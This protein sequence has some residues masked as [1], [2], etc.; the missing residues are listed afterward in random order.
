L[1]RGRRDPAEVRKG[2]ALDFWRV[3][4]VEPGHRLKLVAEMK[5]PGE[6]VLELVLNEF[7]DG[8]LEIRQY[9][10]FKP[11]GLA[12]L[13][14]WYAVVPFHGIVFVGM[15]KGIAKASGVEIVHDPE[16]IP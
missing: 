9:A 2:D 10:R 12:G 8:T 1:S 6:A 14:Y 5:L 13:L 15:L 3:L 4:I 16:R 11:Q 7:P